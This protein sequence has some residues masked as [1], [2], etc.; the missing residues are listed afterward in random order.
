MII[1]GRKSS[2]DE[3]EDKNGSYTTARSTPKRSK[4]S[5]L[6][7]KES[8]KGNPYA[9]GGLDKFYKLLADVEEKKQKIYSQIGAEKISLI[10]FVYSDSFKHVRPIVVRVK[11]SNS[12]AL[13]TSSSV[14]TLLLDERVDDDWNIEENRTLE[15]KKKCLNRSCYSFCVMVVLVLL[16]LAIYGRFFAII[17]ATIMWYLVS[18]NLEGVHHHQGRKGDEEIECI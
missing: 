3:E 4:N 2:S 17:C 18:V 6:N 12:N 16:F 10:R 9:E 1:C 7:G 8:K 5:K 13:T 14:E 15:K 11:N